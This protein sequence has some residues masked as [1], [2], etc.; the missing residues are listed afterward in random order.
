M[1]I[2]MTLMVAAALWGCGPESATVAEAK[3]ALER[4]LKDPGSVQYRDV[5]EFS[6]GVV[7]GEYNAK[8][9][10]GGYVGFKKF[11]YNGDVAGEFEAD[12]ID[13]AVISYCSNGTSKRATTLTRTLQFQEGKCRQ[14]CAPSDPGCDEL[15]SGAA[16]YAC[17]EAPKTREKIALMRGL[18]PPSQQ[19]QK[20]AERTGR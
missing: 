4:Q 7:C 10:M 19:P 9:S 1:R 14:V 8:N 17:G 2:A 11:V 20:A 6:E 12:N 15:S 18:P 5:K 13:G 3:K 16:R